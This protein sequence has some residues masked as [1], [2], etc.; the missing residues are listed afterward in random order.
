MTLFRIRPYTR[1]FNAALFACVLL[2]ALLSGCSSR[3]STDAIRS[4]IAA[5]DV[6]N[7]EKDLK[8]THESYGEMVTALNLARVY[9]LDGRWTDSIRAYG[10][11]LVLLEDYESRAVVNIRGLAESAGVMLL[12]PGAKSYF[13]TGYERSLLHTFNALNYMMQGDFTGAAVEMRRMDQRQSLWLEESQARIEKHLEKAKN[14][15]VA[16][17]EDLPQGY[18]MREL[19]RDESVKNLLNNYQDAFSYALAAIFY[20]LAGD[21]QAAE[22]SMRRAILLD[23]N[24]ARL[25]EQA[26]PSPGNG[27]KAQE[28]LFAVPPLPSRPP[29]G[30]ADGK[31]EALADTQE[32]TVIAFTGL[33]PALRVETVRIWFPAIGYIL[34]DLP[35]Y[36][37]AVNG[38]VPEAR[39]PGL[40]PI[41]LHPLLKTDLLAYRTLW[42]EVRMETASA[43]SRAA[44]RA[45][46]STG[47][48]AAAASN[49]NT[50]DFAPLAGYLATIIQDLFARSMSGSLRNWE[51]LPNTGYLALTA[52]PRGSA[53]TL[54]AGGKEQ[55]I[56][57][58][59]EARGVI[60]MAMEL[61]TTNLKVY[62]VTY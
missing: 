12:S 42:D 19:L 59:L 22:I 47:A 10:E 55:R 15:A 33:A 58:P 32:V 52:V 29:E 17:P 24:A 7:L 11:A 9:Q 34:I 44:T 3:V 48:Y 60:I 36:V 20:R 51:T 30:K 53:L 25:F 5:G 41:A 45:L 50:R 14:T 27:R 61:S 31:T 23:G 56:D 38:A 57:L 6:Q 37:H 62:Y 39:G 35:S 43:V 54:A 49:K 2:A 46:I 4:S 1:R 28:T 16:S 18:S 13:G 40:P 21:F 26:W 8:K